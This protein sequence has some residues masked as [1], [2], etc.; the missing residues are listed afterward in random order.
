[1]TYPIEM[2]AIELQ[3]VVRLQT[4]M[5]EVAP[6][7]GRAADRLAAA[8][9][10]LQG[11]AVAHEGLTALQGGSHAQELARLQRDL[12]NALFEVEQAGKFLEGSLSGSEKEGVLAPIL[13]ET[14]TFRAQLEKSGGDLDQLVGGGSETTSTQSAQG[15]VFTKDE[16]SPG[17]GDQLMEEERYEEACEA[18]VIAGDA[19]GLVEAAAALEAHWYFES[20]A[21]LYFET[22][23]QL[24]PSVTE[25]VGQKAREMMENEYYLEAS[26]TFEVIDDL[27]GQKAALN[28][29]ADEAWQGGDYET[30]ADYYKKAGNTRRL[31][32][33]GVAEALS[34]EL[35]FSR[36]IE[37]AIAL[38]PTMKER[39][40]ERLAQIGETEKSRRDHFAEGIL[41]YSLGN[42]EQTEAAAEILIGEFDYEW[43][44]PIYY[45]YSLTGN[46]PGMV[47]GAFFVAMSDQA[48]AERYLEQVLKF[49]PN[50]PAVIVEEVSQFEEVSGLPLAGSTGEMVER[51]LRKEAEI[52]R[53]FTGKGGALTRQ[54]AKSLVE[55][56]NFVATIHA[57][58]AIGDLQGIYDVLRLYTAEIIWASTWTES[59]ERPDPD[60]LPRLAELPKSFYNRSGAQLTLPSRGRIDLLLLLQRNR[61]LDTEEHFAATFPL[62]EIIYAS[63]D[64]RAHEAFI[65][66]NGG[67][68]SLNRNPDASLYLYFLAPGPD[69]FEAY[70][71]FISYEPE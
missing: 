26:E 20:E 36:T 25:L 67:L 51:V 40:R 45:L 64:P 46:V 55:G 38:D 69:N 37:E 5:R 2:F 68:E 61:M 63:I 13:E 42:P 44:I 17:R 54:E 16:S 22:A 12:S 59:H 62:A 15:G 3:T 27:T 14:T 24:D 21:R 48:Q 47:R 66:E 31:F 60:N 50:A 18:Y 10:Q 65:P 4:A 58:E 56:K 7:S 52:P 30:A 34:G 70:Q 28:A 23:V 9:L 32:E 41:S 39:E 43:A 53:V 8:Q 35:R 57:F 29:A 71:S 19:T 11:I 6:V 33:T 1:M 49:D